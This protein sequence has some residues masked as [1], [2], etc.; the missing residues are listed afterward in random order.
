MHSAIEINIQ[1]IPAYPYW[2]L[3]IIRF[4]ILSSCVSIING[5]KSNCVPINVY[6]WNHFNVLPPTF[7]GKTV[8]IHNLHTSHEY[9]WKALPW[10][11][12]ISPGWHK[13]KMIKTWSYLPLWYQI[14]CLNVNV[15]VFPSRFVF[16][17]SWGERHQCRSEHNHKRCWESKGYH[18]WWL[19]GDT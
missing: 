17:Y 7:I 5:Y 16:S 9:F 10:F 11:L 4:P 14:T 19:R 12:S 2:G 18:R 13:F 1:A 15:R 3:H 6:V 8:L